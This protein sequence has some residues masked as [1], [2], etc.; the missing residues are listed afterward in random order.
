MRKRITNNRI[1]WTGLLMILMLFVVQVLPTISEAEA[2]VNRKDDIV[3]FGGNVTIG[4]EEIVGNVVAFGGSVKTL[5]VIDGDAVVFGGNVATKG[6]I[7]K[8][9]VVFGGSISLEGFVGGDIVAFGGN[10]AI[11]E[12]A[13]LNGDIITFGGTVSK[14]PYA[15]IRGSIID[16]PW[17]WANISNQL[18]G[19]FEGHIF[20]GIGLWFRVIGAI[21]LV[22]ISWIIGALLPQNIN[23]V[24]EIVKVQGLRSFGIG[25]LA[26]FLAGPVIVAL[27]IIIIGIPL[28]PVLILG[29]WF[30]QMMGV[31]AIGLLLGMSFSTKIGNGGISY[32][33]AMLV[34]L[35]ML[36]LVRLVP[37]AG[38]IT[39]FIIKTIALGAILISKFGTGRPWFGA[40]EKPSS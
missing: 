27:M 28:V 9:L 15:A 21:S 7:E 20:S 32:G 23:R 3:R 19:E 17:D 26:K 6:S 8:N 39:I 36:S 29:L 14:H 35:V 37:F 24:A 31:A 40:G 18:I 10:I 34:G 5:G 13:D 4:S 22:A 12:N 11:G 25:L 33:L 16:Q 2:N 1:V 38:G 30:A